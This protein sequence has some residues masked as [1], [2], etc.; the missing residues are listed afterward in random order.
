MLKKNS[1][2]RVYLVAS[3]LAWL[4]I[5]PLLVFIGGGSWLIHRFGWDRR[6]V[7]VFVLLGLL[8]MAGGIRSYA[9]QFFAEHDDL[10]QKPPKQDKRDYDY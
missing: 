3:H 9:R 8:V 2:L 6:V 4:V 5:A 1:A 7:I 10:N